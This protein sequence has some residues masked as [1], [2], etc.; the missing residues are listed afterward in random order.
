MCNT[1]V[2]DFTAP[3][4]SKIFSFVNFVSDLAVDQFFPDPKISACNCN[5]SPFVNKGHGHILTGDR[6]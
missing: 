3:I 2:Y 1:L 5:K 4:R 6:E